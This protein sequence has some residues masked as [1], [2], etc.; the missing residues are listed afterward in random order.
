MRAH[1]LSPSVTSMPDTVGVVELVP[2]RLQVR[3]CFVEFDGDI[4]DTHLWGRG[5]RDGTSPPDSVGVR[6]RLSLTGLGLKGSRVYG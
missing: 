4:D 5:S 2:D 6:V 3:W 1:I